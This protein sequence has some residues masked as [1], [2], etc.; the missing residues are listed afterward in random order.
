M[1]SIRDL[2]VPDPV[3]LAPTDTLRFAAG[4]LSELGVGG[5]PVVVEERVKGVVTM[6]DILE[7]AADNPTGPSTG[8]RP[9]EE[10]DDAGG[11]MAV[12]ESADWDA[13]DEHTV[14]EVMS[15]RILSV[16]PDDE[17]EKAAQL[18]AAE[19]VHRVLV[20]EGERLLG[21][22]TAW[23]VVLA[24]ARGDLVPRHG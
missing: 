11:S 12:P 4:V 18:M 16:G 5:A 23:D 24:V 2:M 8:E 21:I 19:S 1:L 17:A 13:L 14:A 7:F 3:T 10:V 15:R 6:T 9:A 20:M 22:V